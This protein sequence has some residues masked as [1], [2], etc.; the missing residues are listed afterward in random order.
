MKLISI[1]VLILFGTSAYTQ[2]PTSKFP[3]IDAEK[4]ADALRAGPAFITKDAAI[5][6]WPSKPGGEYRVLRRS[7][8]GHFAQLFRRET[9]LSPNDHRRRR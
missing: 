1:M 5:L 4:I 2:Q 3:T 6:D 8:P 7:N 9:G